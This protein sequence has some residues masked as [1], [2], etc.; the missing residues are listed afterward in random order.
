VDVLV[1]GAG[2]MIGRALRPAL[3]GAG[4]R[5]VALRRGPAPGE[6]PRWDPEAGTID[7]AALEG[8]GAVVHLAGEPIASRRWTP[9]QKERILAS[10][11]RGTELLART[12]AGLDAKPAVLVSMSGVDYYGDRGDERLTETSP[13]G[14]GFL[15]EVCRQWEA[16]TKPAADA[17]IRVVT[18]RAGMVLSPKGGALAQ[19]LLPFKLG[20]GGRVGPGTQ[21]V[22]WITLVDAVRGF[23]QLIEDDRISGAVN[24]TAPNP[25]TNREFTKALGAALH[26]PTILPTPL[27]P[28][29]IRYGRELVQH[30]LLD[31]HRVFPDVLTGDGFEFLYDE[32]GPA[33]EGILRGGSR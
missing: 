5:V 23:V 16:A 4:H 20:L 14:A 8:T 6:G 31:S 26:R 27:L 10:R 9:E 7:A 32:I 2:G 22:S 25:V 11:S 17:G 29:R 13:S 21:Y 33:F 28:L 24:L 18:P 19:L 15:A 3:E 1:S 30:L 12:L